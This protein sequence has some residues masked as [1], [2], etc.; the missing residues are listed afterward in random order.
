MMLANKTLFL[1][2]FSLSKIPMHSLPRLSCFE[3][4]YAFVSCPPIYIVYYVLIEAPAL[5]FLCA[6]FKAEFE[7]KVKLDKIFPPEFESKVKLDKIFPRQ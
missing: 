6:L 1:D 5:L 2:L 4:A 3:F 7:S